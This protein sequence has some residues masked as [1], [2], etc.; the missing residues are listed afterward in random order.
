MHVTELCQEEWGKWD[1]Y[2]R[3]ASERQASVGLPQHL[4][5]WQTV[6]QNTYG[7]ETR[8]LIAQGES[9]AIN[10][11]LPLFLI[12]SPLLGTT[13]S[14]LPG[15]LC[16]DDSEAAHALLAQA[17]TITR[18]VGA[19][20][21]VLHDSREAWSDTFNTTCDHED[22]VMDLRGGEA[23]VSAALDRNIR[24]QI[25][26]AQRNELTAVVDR[27]GERLGDFYSV[28]SRFTHQAGTPIFARKFLAEVIA[29]FPDGFNIV[30]VYQG[31]QPLG[32]YF[33]LELGTT[34]YGT[35]GATLHEF[36]ELRPV[37]LA[38]WTIITDSIAQGFE[39]LDMGRSPAGST[40]S[41]YK[42]QW[43]TYSQPIYQQTWSPNGQAGAQN[44]VSVARQAQS[45][46]R[47]QTFRRIWPRLPLPVTQFVGPL[48]RRQI[49]FG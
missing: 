16:A 27:T 26:I 4:A 8:Y 2:V 9:G 14:T 5:G 29:A 1:A 30:M 41:Q 36:L 18:A 34:S 3:Q 13:L 46:E 44:G 38:Y 24:R 7:Y 45:D 48:L 10:G 40:A 47:F 33:Q 31:E 15:G 19:K 23:A 12:R 21:L 28:M 6:L 32:G 20:Q 17:Q 43:A 49:P 35:W 39:K 25:R 37:Y 22:W 42:S 11:V